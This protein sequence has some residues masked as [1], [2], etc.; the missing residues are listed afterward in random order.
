V[1]IS[2]EKEFLHFTLDVDIPRIMNEIP[3]I[4]SF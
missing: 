3:I 4:S 2:K 1:G